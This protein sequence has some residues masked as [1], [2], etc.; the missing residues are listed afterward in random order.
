MFFDQ[1]LI[2]IFFIFLLILHFNTIFLKINK[3]YWVFENNMV[4]L[5]N[6]TIVFYLTYGW[7]YFLSLC[8]FTK[9]ISTNYSD[10]YWALYSSKL[11]KN[12]HNIYF[13]K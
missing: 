2:F 13:R 6:Q 9:W 8:L 1:L 7:T 3:F 5:L 12:F 4:H 11:D 10:A